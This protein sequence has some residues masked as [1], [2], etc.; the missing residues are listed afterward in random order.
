MQKQSVNLQPTSKS[1]PRPTNARPHYEPSTHTHATKRPVPV[2]KQPPKKT[3]V[4][5]AAII[6]NNELEELR[7][8]NRKM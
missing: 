6:S 7:A 1:I 5:P 2:Q 8:Y 4:A 3:V